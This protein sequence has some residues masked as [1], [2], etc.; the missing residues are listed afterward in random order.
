MIDPNIIDIKNTLNKHRLAI[1]DVY[2]NHGVGETTEHKLAFW[3][4]QHPDGYSISHGPSPETE[5]AV[6]E[7]S[8]LCDKFPEDF[9]LC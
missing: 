8:W 7:T 5:V 9:Q 4:S 6:M 2:L 3:R 1:S